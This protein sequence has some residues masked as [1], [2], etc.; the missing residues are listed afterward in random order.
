[1]RFPESLSSVYILFVMNPDI[2]E[3][4]LI[5]DPYVGRDFQLASGESYD[6]VYEKYREDIHLMEEN[7]YR[8]AILPPKASVLLEILEKA[9]TYLPNVEAIY[10]IRNSVSDIISGLRS[11]K[12]IS[13]EAIGMVEKGLSAMKNFKPEDNYHA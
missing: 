10:E 12:P 7:G 13:E 5:A 2:E 3:G 4:K 1:M 11:G 6:A 8:W 9:A